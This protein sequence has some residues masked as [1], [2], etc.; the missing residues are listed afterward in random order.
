MAKN[1]KKEILE[2]IRAYDT[3]V[4]SRH[5]RPDGDEHSEADDR[6]FDASRH[7]RRLSRLCDG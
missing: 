7:I 5:A 3:V 1:V 4:I 2:K 6:S